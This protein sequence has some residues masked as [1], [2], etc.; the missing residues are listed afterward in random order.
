MEI[1]KKHYEKIVLGVVLLG[2]TVAV[3]LLPIILGSK[4]AKLDAMHDVLTHPKI[5]ELPPLDL[6]LPEAALQRV[7]AVA[8]L[9]FTRTHNLFNPVLWLK[10]PEGRPV[11]A[12]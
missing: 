3:A 8:R 5:K 11:K 6:A 4:R 10:S 2:L 12:S 9:D 1:L 7:Q